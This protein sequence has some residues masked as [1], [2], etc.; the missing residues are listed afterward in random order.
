LVDHDGNSRKRRGIP[1][2]ND[3]EVLADGTTRCWAFDLS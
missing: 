2:A 1:A 3:G